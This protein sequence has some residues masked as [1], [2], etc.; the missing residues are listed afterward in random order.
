VLDLGLFGM[1]TWQATF[2]V[3][4]PDINNDTKNNHEID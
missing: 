4:V 1:G 3:G 2:F